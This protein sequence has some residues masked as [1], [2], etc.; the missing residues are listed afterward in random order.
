MVASD[1]CGAPRGLRRERVY[2]PP[3]SPTHWRM[4][5][6]EQSRSARRA[7][8]RHPLEEGRGRT[9]PMSWPPSSKHWALTVSTVPD[10]RP[11]ARY[12]AALASGISRLRF[13]MRTQP[14]ER[15]LRADPLQPI[16]ARDTETEFQVFDRGSR[17][18]ELLEEI[19]VTVRDKRVVDLG[20]G[21]GFLRARC[22]AR[23]RRSRDRGR[24]RPRAIG[25]GPTA[26]ASDSWRSTRFRQICSIPT[27]SLPRSDLAFLIGVV[28]Y[29]GLWDVDEPVEDLQRR[30]FMTAYSA[31]DPGGQLIFGSKNR[32]WPA[33]A[34]R[35]V[36]TQMPLV[37]ALPRGLADRLSHRLKGVPYRHHI[38]S[39]RGWSALL[40]AAGFQNPRSSSLL[41]VPAACAHR[42]SGE[43]CLSAS[44]VPD[45]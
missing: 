34:V 7:I 22:G 24:R 33:L 13:L 15:G 41:L 6:V 30:V 40:R 39:P 14:T 35:D 32:L 2:Y 10:A 36:H 19:N 43:L 20:T 11:A 1:L 12:D 27:V 37:N 5:F 21:Y 17:F 8:L 45:A 9:M 16:P 31:L 29:A 44:P 18:L 3:D 23:F 4:R 28:E 26:R 38:H 42:G 25:A